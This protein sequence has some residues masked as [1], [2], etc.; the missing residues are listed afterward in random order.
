MTP[1]ARAGTMSCM[2]GDATRVLVAALADVVM[3]DA[4]RER[5]APVVAQLARLDG[6]GWLGLDEWAR[7]PCWSRT[8][9]PLDDVPDWAPVLTARTS[10]AGLVAASMCRDGRIREAA[11]QALGHVQAPLAGAAL[12]V[13][14][15]DWVPEVRSAARAAVPARTGAAD[16]A[17]I[18]PVML[19]LN[20][21]YRGREAAASYLARVAGGPAATLLALAAVSD[22]ACVLWALEALKQRRLLTAEVLVDRAMHD[23]DPVVALWCARSLADPSGQLPAE[24]GLRLLAS[25][26]ARVRAFAAGHL[27]DDQLTRQ[28]LQESLLDRSASVRSVARWRWQRQYADPGPVYRSAL[29]GADPPSQIAAAL[30]GLDEDRDAS[31]PE[32]AV[33]FL[34]HQSPRVR[35]AAAQAVGH[36]ADAR[37]V[38]EYLVPLLGDS[39]GKVAAAALRLLHGYPLPASVLTSLSAAGTPRLRRIAL[40]IQQHSGTWSRVHADLAA[41]N[42]HDR[43]LA[44]AGRADL[45]AWLRHGAATSYGQ[46]DAGQATEIAALLRTSKLS[47][48]QRRE[49][50]FVAG[51]RA[52]ATS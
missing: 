46:P 41:I 42:G 7:R 35:R 52:P 20:P 33:P 23:R 34:E 17:A 3:S 29:A 30:S 9:S 14:I 18:V 19:A 45:L 6:R 5:S 15:A 38:I 26:R 39:S 49:I 37:A 10:V 50:A 47:D 16:A 43:D 11:V 21:R 2:S 8:R 22:R 4:D 36:H 1:D 24:G 31:L 12:A 32:V 28:L 48:R 44:D 25:A 27:S 51:I 40:S 13:R